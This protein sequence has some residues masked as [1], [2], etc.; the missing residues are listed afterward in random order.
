MPYPNIEK[1]DDSKDSKSKPLHSINIWIDDNEINDP[2]LI[3]PITTH[4][5]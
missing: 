5:Y 1:M 3:I 2:H 4:Q